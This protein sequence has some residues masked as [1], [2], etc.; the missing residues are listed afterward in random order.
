MAYKSIEP[1]PFSDKIYLD[2]YLDTDDE[3]IL[4]KRNQVFE[5]KR[6][7]LKL[8]QYKF[9]LLKI[10][11]ETSVSL[12]DSLKITEK[13]LENKIILDDSLSIELSTIQTINDEIRKL[14][15]NL[16]DI[17]NRLNELN[18]LISIQFQDYKSIAYNIFA[19]FIHRGEAS[20]GHYWVYIKDPHNNNIF[21]K[22]NDEIVTEVPASEIFNFLE[23]N[24]ATPYYI[25]YIKEELES[26]YIE[27]L[28]GKLKN[29]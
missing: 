6:E 14:T 22:Y 9:D 7:I 2:R 21:R 19:V 15:S 4:Y 24:T 10:D 12:I 23:T 3:E 18:H 8:Q 25:V 16:E 1:I 5:W 28:K 27:P 13:Y 11:P 26:S 17:D 29:K 20:Y